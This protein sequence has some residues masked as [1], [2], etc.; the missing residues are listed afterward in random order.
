MWWHSTG[1]DYTFHLYGRSRQVT[2]DTGYQGE[3]RGYFTEIPFA[4]NPAA[5]NDSNEI[6][7]HFTKD[8]PEQ[9][10]ATCEY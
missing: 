3:N 5:P 6:T 9:L 10:K 2:N 1:S 4:K 7:I 8:F